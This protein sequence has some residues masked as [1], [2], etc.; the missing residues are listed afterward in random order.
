VS[1]GRSAGLLMLTAA[2]VDRHFRGAGLEHRVRFVASGDETGEDRIDVVEAEGGVPLSI[3]LRRGRYGV[4]RSHRDDG[5]EVGRSR[6]AGAS[7][8]R[9][10]RR[11]V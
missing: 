4:V 7:T 11:P 1:H 10:W 3:R 2:M 8:R 9:P 5:G 6:S